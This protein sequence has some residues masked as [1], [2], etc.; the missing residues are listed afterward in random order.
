MPR[1]GIFGS[2]FYEP[3]VPSPLLHLDA[4]DITSWPGSGTT[5][6]DVTPNNR[7]A[8]WAGAATFPVYDSSGGGCIYFDASDFASIPHDAN[9]SL[10]TGGTISFF[11]RPQSTNEGAFVN[12]GYFTGAGGY[13]LW[14]VG[15]NIHAYLQKGSR[16]SAP[17]TLNVW[18]HVVVTWN[19]SNVIIYKNGVVSM[20]A[21]SSI[22]PDN[23]NAPF[24]INRYSGF[25]VHEYLND[26]RVYDT[27][28]G[29]GDVTILFNADRAKYGL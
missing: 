5:W 13:M 27:A 19:G 24:E 15:G 17:L 20:N 26:M 22:L 16:A 1:A 9:L 23:V 18:T 29:A 11:T 6:F 3:V 12:H 25:Y 21:S 8:S 7:D 14:W 2:A 28:L 10:N 4:S